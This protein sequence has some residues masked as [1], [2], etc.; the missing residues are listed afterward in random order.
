M[1]L[2][3]RRDI[4]P[5][6]TMNNTDALLLFQKKLDESEARQDLEELASLLEYMPL[7][8]IQAAAYIQRKGERYSIR[9]YIDA[10]KKSEQRQTVLLKHEA[11]NLRRDEDAKNSIITTWQISFDDIREK[12]PMSADLLSLMSYFDRQGVP[13]TVLKVPTREERVQDTMIELNNSCRDDE[14]DKNEDGEDSG[15][16]EICSDDGF[17]SSAVTDVHEEEQLVQQVR[18]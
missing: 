16:S 7:A 4:I 14:K 17:T 3:E 9:R 15:I 10:F 6:G 1:K 8:I 11:G 13:E 18:Q 12:W 5:I 2:V